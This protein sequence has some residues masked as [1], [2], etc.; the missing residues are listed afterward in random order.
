MLKKTVFNVKL[1]LLINFNFSQFHERIF[2][3]SRTQMFFKT[4]VLKRF[5]N[6]A[7]K[8]LCWSLFLK[9]LQAVGLQLHEKKT[10]AEVFSCAVCEIFNNTFSYRIPPV[11][12]SAPPVAVS[13]FF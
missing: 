13:V 5:A 6:F 7:G 8:H 9:R 10:P 4:G 3:S 11:S 2:R 12:A 1:K